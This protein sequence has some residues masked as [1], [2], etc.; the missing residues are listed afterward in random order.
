MFNEKKDKIELLK[1]IRAGN[2][3]IEDLPEKPVIISKAN[4]VF[5]GIMI[6]ADVDEAGEKSSVVFVGEARHMLEK[7]EPEFSRIADRYRNEDE[8]IA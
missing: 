4:E 6:M 8:S 7:L 2:V 5:Y 3:K 1:A